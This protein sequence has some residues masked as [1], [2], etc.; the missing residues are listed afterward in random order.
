MSRNLR[1]RSKKRSFGEI[2]PNFQT[3]DRL[4]NFFTKYIKPMKLV[5]MLIYSNNISD[6]IIKQK[7]DESVGLSGFKEYL[8][9]FGIWLFKDRITN[10][11]ENITPVQI[12]LLLRGDYGKQI[13]N[14]LLFNYSSSPEEDNS[15]ITGFRENMKLVFL[16]SIFA[17]K[18]I[19]NIK[20]FFKS[21]TYTQI[22]LI[23]NG[24]YDIGKAMYNAF[25]Q[26][27]YPSKISKKDLDELESD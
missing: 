27:E 8:E 17:K 16:R 5:K 3:N 22:V 10:F 4:F 7:P 20:K 1:R 15:K 19:G 23:M 18:L 12:A 26:T 2:I 25:L 11:I 6:N 9:K 14:K 21:L 13:R 24:K